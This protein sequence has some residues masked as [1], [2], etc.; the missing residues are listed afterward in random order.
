MIDYDC[1]GYCALCH[2][3]MMDH[4]VD[5]NGDIEQRFNSKKTNLTLKLNDSSFM[6]VTLCVSCKSLYKPE[7]DSK[8]LMQSIIKGWE[9]ECENLVK[10]DSKPQFDSLWKEKHMS[11]YSK[12]EII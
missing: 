3:Y 4:F 2:E 8:R 6:T 11:A 5:E 7:I 9:V 12:K 1:F 10:D